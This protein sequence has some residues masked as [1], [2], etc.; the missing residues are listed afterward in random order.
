M[1]TIGSQLIS[2]DDHKFFFVKMVFMK[3]H[4]MSGK[5]KVGRLINERQYRASCWG[6][7]AIWQTIDC[8]GC[9]GRWS[10][11]QRGPWYVFTSTRPVKSIVIWHKEVLIHGVLTLTS[12]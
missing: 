12:Q 11:V 2:D 4:Y 9:L 6:R 5:E 7:F 8:G 1:N 10:Q 3:Q